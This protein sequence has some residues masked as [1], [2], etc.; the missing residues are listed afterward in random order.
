MFY[1]VIL[2]L[3]H[4]FGLHLNGKYTFEY[5]FGDN[6]FRCWGMGGALIVSGNNMYM[7]AT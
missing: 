2:V 1:Y 5:F 3:K 6:V 4:L 7:D